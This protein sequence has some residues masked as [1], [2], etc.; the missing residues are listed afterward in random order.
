MSFRLARQLV[1]DPA[2]GV[3]D[4]EPSLAPDAQPA[5]LRLPVSRR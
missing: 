4:A 2:V 1:H 5:A 3:S